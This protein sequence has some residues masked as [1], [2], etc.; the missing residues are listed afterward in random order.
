MG[1]RGGFC[2]SPYLVFGLSCWWIERLGKRRDDPT[3][4]TMT[5]PLVGA[6]IFLT[7]FLAL[8]LTWGIA[9]PQTLA[10]KLDFDGVGLLW[11]FF[12][13]LLWASLCAGLYALSARERTQEYAASGRS[14]V[15]ASLNVGYGLLL[16]VQVVCIYLTQS[17]GPWL[18]LGV[19]IVTF[20]VALWLLGRRNNVNWMRRVGSVASAIVLILVLF[21]GVLNIPNSPIPGALANVPVLGRG[22]ERL[23]TLTRTEDGT[24]KVRSLIWQGATAADRFGPS[25]LHHR[26]G[27]G[28]DVCRL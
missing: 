10:L 27:T 8:T 18:G 7:S 21:V 6:A 23:S 11:T 4:T 17:R 1:A 22:I 24:G 3:L 5:L 15:R 20:M 25:A 28:V 12:F 16:V 19:G 9:D 26:L 13:L 2:P 14:L